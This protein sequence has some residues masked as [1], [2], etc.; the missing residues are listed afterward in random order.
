M[1]KASH[2]SGL[3]FFCWNSEAGIVSQA[4][5]SFKPVVDRLRR[6]L[7]DGLVLLNE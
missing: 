3:L 7:Q 6:K 5:V 1:E 4:E 2:V